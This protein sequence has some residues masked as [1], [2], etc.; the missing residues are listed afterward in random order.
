MTELSQMPED[1]LAGDTVVIRRS[2]ADYPPADWTLKATLA[3]ISVLAVTGTA[4]GSEY[5]L[6]FTAAATQPL[7]PG[8]Y[9]YVEAVEQGSGPTLIRHTVWSKTVHVQPAVIGAAAGALADV[10]EALLAD[11]EVELRRRAG[12]GSID[13]YSIANRSVQRMSMKDLYDLRTRL[14]NKLAIKQH[15]GAWLNAQTRVTFT[16][17]ENE[18]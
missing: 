12:E 5:V 7:A 14:R 18:Q 6:T 1:L 2:Y 15:A 11:I 4:D 9:Q 16:G 3:G 13:A 10:D 17:T 8:L